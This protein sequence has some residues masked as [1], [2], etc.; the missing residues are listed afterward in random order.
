VEKSLA[1]DRRSLARLFT[2][3]ERSDHDLRDVMRQVH[4]HTGNAYCVGITGPPG[5][6]KSTLV[7][8]LVT[9]ARSKGLSVGVLAVDPTSPFSGGAVLGDRIRMQTHYLDRNVFIQV[10]RQ[11][12][13]TAVSLT[14]ATQRSVFWTPQAKTW[15]SSRP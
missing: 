14:F 12:E 1:G 4:P 2:R 11:G 8:A 13:S 7:D 10:S 9:V 5:A 15:F 6:G 3:I